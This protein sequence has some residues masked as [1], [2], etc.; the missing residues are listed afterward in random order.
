MYLIYF[1]ET[2]YEPSDPFFFIGGILI[3]DEFVTKFE[4][5][6]MQ[7]QYNFFGSN[8]LTQDTELH[9]QYIFQGKGPYKKRKLQDRLKLFEDV[10]QALPK[11][12]V[13]VRMV[14]IDVKAHRS[15][16]AYPQPEY[17][18]GL[19]LVLER[20][21]DY[22]EKAR[23][24]GVIF[25][26]YEK[27][28]ITKSILDFSQFKHYVK[29]PMFYGRPLGRLKD[30]I[31]FTQSHHSRFLQIADMVVYM[32][33]RFENGHKPKTWHDKKLFSIWEDLKKNTDYL[34]QRWP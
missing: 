13:D 15:K 24:I 23:E 5:I 33:N 11:F 34:L 17:S 3:S 28:E 20:F 6:I 26:D 2:K 21:C 27:D 19:M 12:E 4:N 1:D 29:T 32:A 18:L 9:G 25:G 16:Y 22:L 14:C 30:T 10:S 8:T 7:I 31:Y